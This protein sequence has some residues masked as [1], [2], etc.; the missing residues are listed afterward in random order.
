[1][2]EMP[3]DAPP[4]VVHI[5]LLTRVPLRGGPGLG[6]LLDALEATPDWAPTHAGLDDPPRARYDRRALEGAVGGLRNV[7]TSPGI[8][9]R[10]APRYEGFFA[11]QDGGT[12]IVRL[13]VAV[14]GDPGVARGAFA[15]GDALAD[16]LT[17]EFG[18]VHPVW[19][20]R[21][22]DPRVQRYGASFVIKA[23]EFDR[24]G[25]GSVTARTWLGPALA[26]TFGRLLGDGGLAGCLPSVRR[27]EW[28][29]I[30]ADLA[31]PPWEAGYEELA[32]AQEAAIACLAPAG[33]FADYSAWSKPKAGA[34]WD[35]LP[36]PATGR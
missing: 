24:Y 25:L 19:D 21:D 35:G 1:M 15:L 31:S 17:P 23:K 29:G 20:G 12:A 18:M 22:P 7:V 28:G 13:D 30:E 10:A 11:A 27:L 4:T 8:V 32:S 2:P 6:R 3:G 36:S 14:A 34:N 26:D 9:R 16:A 33:L 5:V